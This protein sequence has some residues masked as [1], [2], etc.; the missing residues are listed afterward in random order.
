MSKED[1]EQYIPSEYESNKIRCL[2]LDR[3]MSMTLY[4]HSLDELII[5]N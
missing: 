1:S 3:L 4:G 2:H 5:T